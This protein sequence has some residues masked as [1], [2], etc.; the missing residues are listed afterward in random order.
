VPQA[1]QQDI[2]ATASDDEWAHMSRPQKWWM[3]ARALLYS[4]LRTGVEP[5]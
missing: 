5:L 3:E 1:E 2:D 4:W